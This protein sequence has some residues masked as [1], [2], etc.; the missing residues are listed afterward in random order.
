M[1]ILA[2]LLAALLGGA[3]N[4]ATPTA[5]VA[6]VPATSAPVGGTTVDYVYGGGPTT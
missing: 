4:L 5:G 1:T 6:G 3:A 2:I